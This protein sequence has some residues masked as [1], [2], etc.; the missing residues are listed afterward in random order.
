MEP[1]EDFH[2]AAEALDGDERE[3]EGEEEKGEWPSPSWDE[4]KHIQITTQMAATVQHEEEQAQEDHASAVAIQQELSALLGN[5]VLHD[6]AQGLL[7]RV[8]S[9]VKVIR[10]SRIDAQSLPDYKVTLQRVDENGLFHFRAELQR[11]QS[12]GK[13]QGGKGDRRGGGKADGR[14]SGKGKGTGGK[15]G[16]RGGGK[17]TGG[18][19]KGNGSSY[20][21]VAW[22]RIDGS[23]CMLLQLSYS[24]TK[25]DIKVDP[26]RGQKESGESAEA[27]ACREV[28]E[29]SAELLHFEPAQ[30]DCAPCIKDLFHVRVRFESDAERRRFLAAYDTNRWQIVKGALGARRAQEADQ[31]AEPV[32]LVWL[33]PTLVNEDLLPLRDGNCS[34]S[35]LQRSRVEMGEMLHGKRRAQLRD[36]PQDWPGMA[37]ALAKQ[38]RDLLERGQIDVPLLSSTCCL[39][40]EFS[41][42]APAPAC[43][44]PEALLRRIDEVLS[45][46]ARLG[47][48]AG[49]GAR[50]GSCA[51]K[52][53]ELPIDE[54]HAAVKQICDPLHPSTD[55]VVDVARQVLSV[56]ANAR[57][58]AVSS[59]DE[60]SSSSTPRMHTCMHVWTHVSMYAYM[61]TSVE[62]QAAV[63][64]RRG[65]G[66]GRRQGSPTKGRGQVG[67]SSLM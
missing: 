57:T 14:G 33:D 52:I 48:L 18:K 32:A 19:G 25:H 62:F 29:E 24:V 66:Q 47:G 34:A 55:L 67:S 60:A 5:A 17:G 12:G 46:S 3:E 6:N 13:G 41:L 51:V 49:K 15:G 28:S 30:L 56:I 9:Q 1:S 63:R 10:G 16:G 45:R 42:N 40:L 7:V 4:A 54:L 22:C 11:G 64:R 65:R 27:T 43:T 21:I 44:V 26:L 50:L 20:G 36:Y 61:Y 58:K 8:A 38:H 53:D 35:I 59:A 37:Q 23:W 31:P 39:H 2:D